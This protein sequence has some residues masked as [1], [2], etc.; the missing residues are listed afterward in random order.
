MLLHFVRGCFGIPASR[1]PAPPL[2][3][4]GHLI[5]KLGSESLLLVLALWFHLMP[6]WY[7][8]LV[9]RSLRRASHRWQIPGSWA[10][11]IIVLWAEMC[12]VDKAP[13]KV[14]LRKVSNPKRGDGQ[15][16]SAT[17]R[18]ETE[19]KNSKQCPEKLQLWQHRKF[20]LK[21]EGWDGA[22]SFYRVPTRVRG[23][24]RIVKGLK[25]HL[26]EGTALPATASPAHS[27]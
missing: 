10:E 2:N 14:A 5:S 15:E 25:T 8:F 27:I 4:P 13:R 11:H 16:D 12:E 6:A 21:V 18:G 22:S 24:E 23:R 3:L 19:R 17:Q 26:Q 9:K 1:L 7:P 20:K